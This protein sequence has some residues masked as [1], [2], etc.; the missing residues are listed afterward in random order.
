MHKQ[1]QAFLWIIPVLCY[2]IFTGCRKDETYFEGEARLY[3]SSDTIYFDTVFTTIG[4]ATKLIKLYNQENESVKVDVRLDKGD[5]SFFRINVDGYSGNNLKDIEILPRDSIYVFAEVTVDPDQPLSVSPF[6]IEE[7]LII[8]QGG[9]EKRIICTAWGQNANYISMAN[10]FGLLTC[11]NQALVFSDPKPYV[12]YGILLIDECTLVIPKGAQIHVHGAL[13]VTE[14]RQ[15][16]NDGQIIVLENG[17]LQIDGTYDE[18]VIIQGDRLEPAYE[19]LDGQWGGIRIYSGSKGSVINNAVIKNSL[20]GLFIDSAAELTIKNS[21]V[22]NTSYSGI[23]GYHGAL[24][25]ENILVYNNGGS[26]FQGSYGGNYKFTYSTFGS[27]INQNEAIAVNNKKCLNLD[28]DLNCQV[29]VDVNPL[30][31]S[32]TNCIIAGG[33]ADELFFDDFTGDQVA[34]DFVYVLKNCIVKVDEL[35]DSDNFPKF[36]DNCISCYNL[37]PGDALFV[38]YTDNDYRLDTSSVALNK[39]LPVPGIVRDL[40]GKDRDGINPDPGCYEF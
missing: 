10:T 6:V 24:T 11:D 14:D 18:P 8:T 16:Y 5:D 12:I 25:A 31:L 15:Y 19:E 9:K 1:K 29:L 7:D 26:C 23:I 22:R 3:A 2:F 37:K 4:S 36:F 39:G 20:V 13:G 17:K 30:Q 32:L 28:E 35:L 34:G 27:Y 33:S 40:T 38:N 21:I